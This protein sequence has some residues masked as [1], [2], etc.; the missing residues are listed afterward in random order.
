[1][2]SAPIGAAVGFAQRLHDLAQ[3]HVLGLGEVGVDGGEH[4]VH[5]RLGQ[6]VERRLQF[7]DLRALGALQRVEVGPAAAQEA[8]GRD[9]RLHVHLLARHRQVGLAGLQ[10]EGIGLGALREGFDHRRMGHVAGFGAVDRGHVLQAVE[11]G[12]PV[13]GHAAGVVEVGLVELLDVRGVA[14]EQVR[15]G[16]GIAASSCAHLSPAVSAGFDGL[17]NLPRPPAAPVGGLRRGSGLSV[18]GP[19]GNERTHFDSAG[20]VAPGWMHTVEPHWTPPA[21]PP[22]NAHGRRIGLRAAQRG[23]GFP[24]PARPAGLP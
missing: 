23:P 11:V 17:N 7:G 14:A 24:G 16:P 18:H 13:V 8:V 10:R 5:V 20:T 22:D 12:A 1:M 9:Q 3:R 4:D 15:V 19:H 2:N 21:L 6:V